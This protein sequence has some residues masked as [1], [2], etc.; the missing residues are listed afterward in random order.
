MTRLLL[1]LYVAIS[2]QR[3]HGLLY[4]L[5]LSSSHDGP[6]LTVE[7]QVSAQHLL[8]RVTRHRHNTA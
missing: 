7:L 6:L 2:L 3:L 5:K 4:L 1:V 8:G